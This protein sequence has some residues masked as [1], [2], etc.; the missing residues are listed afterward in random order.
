VSYKLRLATDSREDI[1]KVYV[2]NRFCNVRSHAR[3]KAACWR[4][5]GFLFYHAGKKLELLWLECNTVISIEV[6][7]RHFA[8]LHC[9][10]PF[11]C[12]PNSLSLA[13]NTV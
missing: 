2:V 10:S 6:G 4:Y 7:I 9:R 11:P 12:L 8:Y 5:F 13:L 1:A 3:Q